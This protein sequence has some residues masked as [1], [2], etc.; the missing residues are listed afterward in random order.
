[1]L[2]GPIPFNLSI[3]GRFSALPTQASTSCATSMVVFGPTFPTMAVL[4]LCS[5]FM[6]C[7]DATSCL[8]L[9]G[10]CLSFVFCISNPPTYPVIQGRLGGLALGGG[11]EILVTQFPIYPATHTDPTPHVVLVTSPG[12]HQ[13]AL[14]PLINVGPRQVPKR[15]GFSSTL[16]QPGPD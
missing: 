16:V 14:A 9:D 13:G 5:M 7:A 11:G 4:H 2:S 3:L 8:P 15:L 10:C 6:V 1:M 12:L